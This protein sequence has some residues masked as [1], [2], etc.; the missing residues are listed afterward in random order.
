MNSI[1]GQEFMIKNKKGFTIIELLIVIVIIGI[2]ITI[3][4]VTFRGFVER[5][6]DTSMQQRLE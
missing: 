6:Q 4:A 3:T 1:E 5:A 2:L